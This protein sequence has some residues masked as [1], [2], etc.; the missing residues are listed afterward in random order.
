MCCF[1]RP[2]QRVS[3][4][5]IFAR[6]TAADTQAVV[7]QMNLSASEDLAMILP[8]PVH[9]EKRAEAVE[10]VNL[11]DYPAFFSDLAKAFPVVMPRSNSLS[12][13]KG[14]APQAAP[15]PVEQV[16][17]FEASYVPGVGDFH[18]LDERFRLPAGTWDKLPAYKDYGFAVFKLKTG[19]KKI[20]PMAMTFRT[21]LTGTLFFPTV[22]IHD[23][24]VHEKE[25]FDHT[26]YAQ[27][28]TNA[29]LSGQDWEESPGLAESVMKIKNARGLVWGGGHIYRSEIRGTRRNEDILAKARLMGG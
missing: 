12:L 5:R 6:C 27:G 26:L 14:S 10:F 24:Q 20:H 7:Y 16:G 23:G 19:E 21:A 28:W 8:L 4:T 17:S 15:L 22:H 13:D 9:P 1:S 18:R 2:V 11:E 25:D 29:L 3:K